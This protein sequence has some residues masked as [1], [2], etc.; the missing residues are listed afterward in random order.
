MASA[1][2][3]HDFNHR[4]RMG[5]QYADILFSFFVAAVLM[6]VFSAVLLGMVFHHRVQRNSEVSP[7]LRDSAS[8][9]DDSSVVFVNLNATLLIFIASWSSSLAPSLA[10]FMVS[11]AS[12]PVAGDYMRIL[13]HGNPRK[14]L[15]PYQLALTLR[16]TSGGGLSALWQWILYLIGWN[17]S[18]QRQARPLRA[19]SSIFCVALFLRYVTSVANFATAF[20][21]YP[22]KRW[23]GR[24]AAC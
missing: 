12:Y 8:E 4:A 21:S 24:R 9:A 7:R 16:F 5:G 14:L 13:R 23:R 18:R 19:V 11:L 1:P 6:T 15:T 17:T 22:E 10:G 20:L 2:N 3:K